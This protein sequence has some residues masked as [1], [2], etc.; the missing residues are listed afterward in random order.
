M[1][2]GWDGGGEEAAM[3]FFGIVDPGIRLDPPVP[4]AAND[5]FLHR[6]HDGAAAVHVVSFGVK[7]VVCTRYRMSGIF[8]RYRRRHSLSLPSPLFLPPVAF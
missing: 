1:R 6:P 5:L 8:C 7:I 2:T 3:Q 4:A